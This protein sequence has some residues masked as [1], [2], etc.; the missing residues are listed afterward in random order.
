M[1]QLS[2]DLSL[3]IPMPIIR[4]DS[5]DPDTDMEEI[6]V[7]EETKETITEEKIEDGVGY[8]LMEYEVNIEEDTTIIEKMNNG[9]YYLD[10]EEIRHDMVVVL[11]A[12]SNVKG[13]TDE[14]GAI[15]SYCKDRK[16]YKL[17]EESRIL[18]KRSVSENNKFQFVEFSGKKFVKYNIVNLADI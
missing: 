7:V 12:L 1:A 9:A 4:K 11:P 2:P 3:I 14:Y 10:L 16:T 17:Q 5:K 13:N 6:G 18:N 8:F 15:E